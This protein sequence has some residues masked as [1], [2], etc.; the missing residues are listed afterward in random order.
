[1][2]AAFEQHFLA[3]WS[4]V[5]ARGRGTA[6]FAELLDRYGEPWRRYHTR[7]HLL[8][9]L[10]TLQSVP[11]DQILSG[12]HLPEVQAALWFHDAVYELKG[13]DNEALSAE[14]AKERLQAAG[15][16]SECIDRIASMVLA[17]KHTATPSGAG[18]QLLVD[19]D[20]SILGAPQE[21]FAE[22]QRQIRDEYSFVPALVFKMKR[23]EILKGFLDRPRIFSTPYF[24]DRLES[25]ARRNLLSAV[26]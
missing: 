9:C 23:R 22:Y 7:Q 21:R 3:M 26:A 20:L 14:I 8:E 2:N 11:A 25:T 12:V 10:E 16:A 6:T 15:V 17:T 18:E 13:A 19:V 1:M 5:G 4:G 24:H